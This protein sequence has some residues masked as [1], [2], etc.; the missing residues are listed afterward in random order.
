MPPLCTAGYGLATGNLYFFLGAFYLFFINA[1]MIS[2][3]TLIIV[4]FLK[5]PQK[6]VVDKKRA[7]HVKR[8]ISVIVVLTVLPSIY[9]GYQIIQQTI[10]NSNVQSYLNKEFNFEK[11]QIV[12]K[13]IAYHLTD[14]CSIE[15]ILTGKEITKLQIQ[16]LSQLLNKYSLYRTKL[17]VKQGSLDIQSVDV[18]QIKS[19]IIEEI[20]HKNELVIQD[21][22]EKIRILES[23]LIKAQNTIPSTD[24]AEEIYA[25]N[26]NVTQF[27]AYKT[28]LYDNVQNVADTTVMVYVSVKGRV[29]RNDK[30]VL[31]NWLQKRLHTNKLKLIIE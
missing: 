28:V 13:H 7:A 15:V 24:I 23:A 21:K 27:S 14:T 11:T 8:Y 10:F 29:K 2:L 12:G 25:I 26:P 9:F 16:E 3:S 30:M 20:Y 6:Q 1:V 19:G 22:D 17:I 18:G 31:Y 4:R 5:F